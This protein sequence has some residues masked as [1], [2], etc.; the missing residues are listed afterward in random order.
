MKGLG[1]HNPPPE[2]P[3]FGRFMLTLGAGGWYN[4]RGGASTG[5]ADAPSVGGMSIERIR[6]S[7][8][9]ILINIASAGVSY[10]DWNA[11]TPHILF[12]T[13]A[14]DWEAILHPSGAPR[15]FGRGFGRYLAQSD[16]SRSR[17]GALSE[18]Q[19][20]ELAFLRP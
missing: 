10:R 12:L 4:R 1:P 11:D 13:H 15:G 7:N 17:V 14:P 18:G 2:P 8:S 6:W 19:A 16:G 5:A 3:D 9:T 20:V